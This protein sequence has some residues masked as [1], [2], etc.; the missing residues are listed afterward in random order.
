MGALNW[1]YCHD[2]LS[3]FLECLLLMSLTV[4]QQSYNSLICGDG[5]RNE[6][7]FE[8][9]TQT[10]TDL[11]LWWAVFPCSAFHKSSNRSSACVARSTLHCSAEPRCHHCAHTG[12]VFMSWVS[13]SL[14]EDWDG[15]ENERRC[16]DFDRS[17]ASAFSSSAIYLFIY[18][19]MNAL[20]LIGSRHWAS[21]ISAGSLCDL[22]MGCQVFLMMRC[23]FMKVEEDGSMSETLAL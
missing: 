12:V 16:T 21:E 1:P 13:Y 3:F 23:W 15:R 9:N 14:S 22:V 4:R 11:G 18:I 10:E 7:C 17:A 8:L 2:F 19:V 6:R 5:C 20:L